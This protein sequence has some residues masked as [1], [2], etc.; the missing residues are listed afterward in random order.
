MSYLYNSA[1]YRVI[2][3]VWQLNWVDVPPWPGNSKN[4]SQLV[5]PTQLSDHQ[6]H[7]AFSTDLVDDPLHLECLEDV[8]AVA[9]AVLHDEDEDGDQRQDHHVHRV[10]PLTNPGRKKGVNKLAPEFFLHIFGGD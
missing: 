10:Q 6:N 4:L 8:G 3:V 5:N 1:N 2:L 7:P 9:D